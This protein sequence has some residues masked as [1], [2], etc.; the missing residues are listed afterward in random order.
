MSAQALY[1]LSTL[2]LGLRQ[3]KANY[4]CEICV[5]ELHDNFFFNLVIITAF[6]EECL[7]TGLWPS[8]SR[9]AWTLSAESNREAINAF[10][11]AES[12]AKHKS[13]TLFPAAQVAF[14]FILHT[15]DF[16]PSARGQDKR[17]W[18]NY[19]SWLS[20]FY[21][22]LRLISVNIRFTARARKTDTV[23]SPFL[24]KGG[25]V[26]TAFFFYTVRHHSYLIDTCFTFTP[27]E[28]VC[29]Y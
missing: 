24:L 16:T 21:K 26:T 20:D 14:F 22:M 10:I 23:K 3:I 19:I 2:H 28:S 25:V 8:A 9:A 11:S 27:D 13:E 17:C 18:G 7:L 12:S 6:L 4:R 1:K 15:P 29:F 5:N